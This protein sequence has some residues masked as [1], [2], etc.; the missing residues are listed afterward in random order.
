MFDYL[1]K[2]HQ[3]P[4]ELR[5][6]ISSPVV[7]KAIS[8]LEKEYGITLASV[9]MKTM[10]K[11]IAVAT[12]EKYFIEEENFDVAKAKELVKKMR[13]EVFAIVKDYL[14]IN[15]FWDKEEKTI[16]V[17]M[18]A[19]T[20]GS[21]FPVKGASFFFSSE[22]E[23]EIRKLAE[24]ISRKTEKKLP[25]EKIEDKLDKIMAAVQINFGSRELAARF[26][27]ILKTY[28]RGVRDKIEI[29]QTLKKTFVDG[30]LSFDRNSADQVI[31]IADK[32][33]AR[34]KISMRPPVKM[35][36]PEDEVGNKN[37][38]G[39][40]SS[41]NHIG[42]RDIDYDFASAVSKKSGE[43]FFSSSKDFS[44]KKGEVGK[45]DIAHE[46]APPPPNIIGRSVES[47]PPSAA[48]SIGPIKPKSETF[49]RKTSLSAESI[50]PK[51]NVMM[52]SKFR[53]P[54]E[55]SGKKRMED[56]KYIPSKIMNSVDELRYMDLVSFHRL[57]TRPEEQVAKIKEKI[58]L[59]EEEQYSKRA[60]GVN[61]WRQSPVNRLYL[62]IG[63]KSI[64]ENKPI[65]LVIEEKKKNGEDY[66]TMEELRAIIDL[67]KELRF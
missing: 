9:V 62:A 29:K 33:K 30:G 23:E 21:S 13:Q 16:G 63:Q 64:S 11:E 22:D 18:S 60:E 49:I 34:E 8:N 2:F 52:K 31:E 24:D 32:I 12:L 41:L 47:K 51:R 19:G 50:E 44:E 26:R 1:Q 10:I 35:K 57:A 40:V 43:N 4:K 17:K 15:N 5:D 58:N 48:K 53:G 28:L 45:L 6:K 38:L 56:V 46:L 37:N 7:M 27:N 61:G 65:E 66:L 67:N 3:L 14:G 20:E 39:K 54:E 36:M 59:L 25:A 55:L 42:V